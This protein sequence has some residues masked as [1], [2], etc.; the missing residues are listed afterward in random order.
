MSFG[1]S[2]GDFLTTVQLA[3]KVRREFV[4]APTQ[5]Q[6]ISDEARNL[7]IVLD[8][9]E[10]ELSSPRVSSKQK[11]DLKDIC[12]SCRR[13]FEDIRKTLDKYRCLESSP[14]RTRDAAKKLW[15]RVN[16]EPED[17]CDLRRR[18]ILNIELLNAWRQKVIHD[19]VVQL[20]QLVKRQK[21]QRRQDVLKWLSPL[22]YASQQADFLSRRQPGTG[23]WFLESPEYKV[24]VEEGRKTLFCPGIPGA[25]KTILTSAVIDDLMSRLRNDP[26]IGM[27]YIY[28]NFRESKEKTGIDLI[29]SLLRQLAQWQTPLPS[30]VQDMYDRQQNN[31]TRPSMDEASQSLRSVASLYTRVFVVVDALDEC[32]SSSSC[33]DS[34]L[35]TIFHLQRHQRVNI[36]ATSRFIPL[37][38]REFKE[39]MMVK[40]RANEED[41]KI[42]VR[43]R[44]R[45]LRDFVQ[46]NP[47][48]QE[49]IVPAGTV[50]FG[51][52]SC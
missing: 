3:K 11:A 33:R 21:D 16:W 22:D 41:V 51:Y 13:V 38:V 19:G 39:S 15:K 2:V 6:A 37:I 23:K 25:G 5:F 12:K 48:L 14:K 36:M 49:E 34:F 50:A 28:F 42:Y 44:I 40:I 32:E 30:A 31:K 27:A 4:D 35:S 8:D 47:Q 52:P 29:L 9:I 24:W 45:E 1:F 46:R 18:V 43:H 20:V 10:I 26:T 7:S 17:I